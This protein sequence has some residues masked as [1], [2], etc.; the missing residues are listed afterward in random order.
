MQNLFTLFDIKEI[1]ETTLGAN[2]L[3]SE[4]SEKLQWNVS[5]VRNDEDLMRSKNPLEIDNLVIELNP[6]EI[7]TFI[8]TYSAKNE[9]GNNDD[10]NDDDNNGEDENNDDDNSSGKNTAT[11]F[12]LC[13]AIIIV[14]F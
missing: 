2:Q 8:I 11:V 13:M 6:M 4:V 14:W 12:L 1:E 7:R 3:L 9:G 10:D 5:F